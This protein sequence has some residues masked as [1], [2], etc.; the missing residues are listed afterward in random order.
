M[1]F[2]VDNGKK[3]YKFAFMHHAIAHM[4]REEKSAC[5]IYTEFTGDRHVNSSLVS[6][7][8]N[9]CEC[10]TMFEMGIKVKKRTIEKWVV[11]SEHAV[12]DELPFYSPTNIVYSAVDPNYST[13][14]L[15][16]LIHNIILIDDRASLN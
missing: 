11:R 10:R 6:N 8:H 3:V 7:K 16:E 9:N 2:W 4:A 15:Q 14:A 5:V 12:T 13:E 1:V